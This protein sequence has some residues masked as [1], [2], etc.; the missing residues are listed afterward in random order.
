MC[1]CVCGGGGVVTLIFSHIRT[2]G[3]FGGGYTILNVLGKEMLWVFLGSS[4]NWTGF[5]GH[6]CVF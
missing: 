6:F 2:L 5:R 3:P 1:V 4:Q